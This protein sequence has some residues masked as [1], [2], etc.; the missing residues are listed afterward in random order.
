L[1]NNNKYFFITI[2]DAIHTPC[3][4]QSSNLSQSNHRSTPLDIYSI[5]G[6]IY[7]MF[8]LPYR[9]YSGD[10]KAAHLLFP[11][12]MYWSL[13]TIERRPWQDKSLL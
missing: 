10:K 12:D 8:S 13:F 5:E 1:I 9:G 7:Q 6:I 3:T 2:S 11:L 4:Q